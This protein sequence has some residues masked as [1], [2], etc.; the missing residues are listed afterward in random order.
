MTIGV[1]LPLPWRAPVPLGPEQQYLPGQFLAYRL[2]KFRFDVGV[3][4]V[5]AA[6]DVAEHSRGAEDA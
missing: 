2:L 5:R 4:V 6:I 1:R 3:D